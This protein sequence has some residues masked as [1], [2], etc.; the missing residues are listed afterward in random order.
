MA[1]AVIASPQVPPSDLVFAATTNG[2]NC[3]CPVI[4]I[5][6]IAIA[7]KTSSKRVRATPTPN[8]A[9]GSKTSSAS[10]LPACSRAPNTSSPKSS[11]KPPIDSKESTAKPPIDSI[12]STNAPPISSMPPH[13]SPHRSEIN[14][15]ICPCSG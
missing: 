5:T 10:Q 14:D 1:Y 11:T 4:A 9:M 3:H 6:V 12:L 7:Y 2:R 8:S 15:I 13:I